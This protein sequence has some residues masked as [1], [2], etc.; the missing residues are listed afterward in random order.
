MCAGIQRLVSALLC[1]YLTHSCLL[2]LLLGSRW[3]TP[4]YSAGLRLRLRWI[5]LSWVVLRWILPWILACILVCYILAW[6]WGCI[7]LVG[8][9]R[10]LV[11]RIHTRICI[12]VRGFF[13]FFS[14]SCKALWL[15]A[16][17]LL[18]QFTVSYW[19]AFVYTTVMQTAW[20]CRWHYLTVRVL[21]RILGLG[22]KCEWRYRSLFTPYFSIWA[23]ACYSY[24]RLSIHPDTLKL[25]CYVFACMHLRQLHAHARL[26]EKLHPTDSLMRT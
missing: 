8:I 6:G 3:R 21:S 2:S 25:H 12:G 9:L 18:K 26:P 20:K 19:Y 5:V 7:G 24:Y 10:R 22:E 14:R 17:H 13:V 23:I 16:L 1:V 4:L 15:S 11:G